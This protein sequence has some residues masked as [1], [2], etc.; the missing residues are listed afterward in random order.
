[1][2]GSLCGLLCATTDIGNDVW[3]STLG[4]DAN[5]SNLLHREAESTFSQLRTVSL[6]QLND[7][8]CAFHLLL[9]DESEDVLLQVQAL[10]DWCQGF[11]VGLGAGGIQDFT[12][13]PEDVAEILKDLSGIA[14]AGTSYD[15]EGSEEDKDSYQQLVEYVRVGVL[16]INEELHP[17]KALPINR[18]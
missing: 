3:F 4:L 12:R 7:S 18:P 2:H 10:G 8:L 11:L 13:Q 17:I 9:P 5:P 15:L 16:L 14:C 1:M 6:K